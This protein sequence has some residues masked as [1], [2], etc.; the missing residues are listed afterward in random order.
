MSCLC[1]KCCKKCG[2][3]NSTR[4]CNIGC[5]CR[6]NTDTCS[7]AYLQKELETKPSSEGEDWLIQ[8][9]ENGVMV[10]W[11]MFIAIDIYLLTIV[12]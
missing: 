8:T 9:E 2:C 11:F 4:L 3:S 1:N 7:Q 12:R 6:G 10:S 5:L